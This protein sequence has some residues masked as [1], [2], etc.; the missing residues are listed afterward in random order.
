MSPSDA[1]RI[2][3]RRR[4]ALEVRFDKLERRIEISATVSEAVAEAFA[5]AKDLPKEVPSVTTNG[6][7]GARYVSPSDAPR[8]VDRRR[9]PAKKFA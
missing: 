5:N 2:V 7:A 9:W 8:I 1:L 6:I 4:F 3:E